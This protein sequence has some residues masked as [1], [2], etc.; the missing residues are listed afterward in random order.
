MFGVKAVTAD[1]YLGESLRDGG[2]A[3]IVDYSRGPRLF[4]NVRDEI[5]EVSPGM[6]LGL[7]YV[8]RDGVAELT[9][10]FALDARGR[11]R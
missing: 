1:W 2:P 8:T 4:R 11:R 10:L 5:R 3:L 6:F 7:T 9:N